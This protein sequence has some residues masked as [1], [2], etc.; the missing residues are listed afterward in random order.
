MKVILKQSGRQEISEK[1]DKINKSLKN[2]QIKYS[3]EKLI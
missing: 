3:E 1:Y 2:F